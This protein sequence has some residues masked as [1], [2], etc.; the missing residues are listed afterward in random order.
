MSIGSPAARRYKAAQ[1]TI[2]GVPEVSATLK[3]LAK[4]HGSSVE[5]ALAKRALRAML[6]P[7]T[8]AIKKDAPTVSLS[9]K[10]GKRKKKLARVPIIRKSVGSRFQ[11]NKRKLIHEAKAGLNVSKTG[12]RQFRQAHLYTMGTRSRR[13]RQGLNRGRM[14]GTNFV[15]KARERSQTAASQAGLYAIKKGLPLEVEKVRKRHE[16]RAAAT[17]AASQ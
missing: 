9:R 10:T 15:I 6:K 11:R 1:I 14:P 7:V 3:E 4:D 2:T 16:K 8:A 12:A 5:R 17:A 13:T